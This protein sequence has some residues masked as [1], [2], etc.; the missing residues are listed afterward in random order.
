MVNNETM[1]TSPRWETN[2]ATC[3]YNSQLFKQ[4]AFA[5]K[6]L[7]GE[8]V[9]PSIERVEPVRGCLNNPSRLE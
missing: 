1:T 4:F 5:V 9:R 3:P 2:A 8:I 6:M 7:A